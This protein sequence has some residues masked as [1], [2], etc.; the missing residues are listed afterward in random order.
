M[1]IKKNQ[2]FI[3]RTRVPDQSLL[4]RQD[5]L[6]NVKGA[7]TVT[8]SS[9]VKDKTILLVDDVLTTGTTLNECSRVLKE[10]GA[11]KIVVAVIAS[12]RRF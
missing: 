7:F 9:K 3:R 5:R 1:G 10:A 11:K 8:D 4:P 2:S 12:G 6:I